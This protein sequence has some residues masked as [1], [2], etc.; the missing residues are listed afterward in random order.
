[1]SDTTQA[2]SLDS[3]PTGVVLATP[4]GTRVD[5]AH[6]LGQPPAQVGVEAIAS[7][8]AD[9]DEARVWAVEALPRL[10]LQAR[11]L[12]QLLQERQQE[13]DR[14]EARQNAMA[15][16][17]DGQSRSIHAWLAARQ[18]ELEQR[19]AQLAERERQMAVAASQL[20]AAEAYQ[21]AARQKAAADVGQREDDVAR[22]ATELDRVRMRLER[23][24]AA[25][26]AAQR[27]LVD[28][29]QRAHD[30]LVCH[31]Q[32]VDHHRAAALEIV[33][34]AWANLEQR[35]ASLA[36]QEADIERGRAEL[37]VLARRPSTEQKAFARE[38]QQIADRLDARDHNLAEAEQLQIR[39]AAELAALRLHL[40]EE[41]TRLEEQARV[42]RRRMAEQE[43]AAIAELSQQRGALR[44]Q[45][46]LLNE[47]QAGL[48]R[49]RAELM[50]VHG[51]A[52]ETRLA[53]EETL[54]RLTGSAAPAEVSRAV[55]E[56][57]RR[58]AD[59]WRLMADG[60]ADQ[61]ASLAT[62]RN[63]VAAQ[64]EKLAAQQQ[65]LGRWVERRQEEFDR[66]QDAL[67]NREEELRNL[68]KQVHAE[69]AQWNH[70]RLMLE[71]QMRETISQ[72]R[73]S[74]E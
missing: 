35:R 49:M 57:R 10:R 18:E 29:R 19:D 24:A 5:A 66:Q 14:R 62:V 27:D 11:Q 31:R 55:A 30:E 41:R 15:A 26:Q 12:A 42:E 60:I 7:R 43:R 67:D 72:L 2:R 37:A 52:L 47:R 34:L 20:S 40:E 6:T 70:G 33:R 25:Q 74:T 13:L 36:D 61:R 71:Q 1:M 32:Q 39:A 38:L 45:H 8:P 21:E 44:R 54:A 9:G 56:S 53:A 17:L 59:H 3:V 63:E 58:L 16:E 69:Q 50:D 28:R 73:E 68:A 22:R 4:A 23:Q 46:E 48:E 64:S 65:E 51:A